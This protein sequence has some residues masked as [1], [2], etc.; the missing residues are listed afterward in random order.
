MVIFGL[1]WLFSAIFVIFRY[2]LTILGPK[3]KNRATL[4]S[5]KMYFRV[6]NLHTKSKK[7]SF[8]GEKINNNFLVK[9]ARCAPPLRSKS[10]KSASQIFYRVFRE[11]FLRQ[12]GIL[13]LL[14]DYWSYK[15]IFATKILFSTKN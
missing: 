7:S 1:K 13:Y 6:E 15:L 3:F 2:F 12:I 5:V 11:G 14:Y 9:T 10:P 4:L 8:V